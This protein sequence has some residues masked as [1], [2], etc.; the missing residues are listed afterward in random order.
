MLRLCMMLS[1]ELYI[2]RMIYIMDDI[3]KNNIAMGILE[4][5]AEEDKMWKAIEEAQLKEFIMSLEYYHY[6]KRLKFSNL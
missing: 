6:S 2:P 3:L 1:T 5:E 4:E